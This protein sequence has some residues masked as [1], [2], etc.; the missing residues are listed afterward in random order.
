MQMKNPAMV[1]ALV[2]LDEGNS[3]FP[4]KDSMGLLTVGIGHNLALGIPASI[5]DAL[6]DLDI[7]AAGDVLTRLLPQWPE[8]DEVRQ[9]AL[10]SLAFNLGNRLEGFKNFLLAVRVGQWEVAAAHLQNS[11]WFGQV[12]LRGPRL[13]SMIHTGTYPSGLI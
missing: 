9:A 13:V 5:V 4:Y 8:L 1:K 6:Y 12:G 10:L 2:T 3:R 7:A 11:K